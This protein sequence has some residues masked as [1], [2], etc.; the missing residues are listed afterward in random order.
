MVRRAPSKDAL[1]AEYG[2]ML[3]VSKMGIKSFNRTIMGTISAVACA[4]LLTA[5]CARDHNIPSTPGPD[6]PLDHMTEISLGENNDI[7]ASAIEDGYRVHAALTQLYGWFQHFDN[8]NVPIDHQ[9]ALLSENA[10]LTSDS[11]SVIGRTNYKRAAEQIPGDWQN[12]HFVRNVRVRHADKDAIRLEADIIYLNS[13]ALDERKPYGAVL[14]FQSTLSHEKSGL[15]EIER[16]VVLE[17]SSGISPTFRSAY[18]ENRLKSLFHH[19][20]YLIASPERSADQF[21][22]I[23]SEAFKINFP[24]SRITSN[25]GLADWLAGPAAAAEAMHYQVRDFDYEEL[26]INEYAMTVELD[27]YGLMENGDQLTGRVVQDFTVIDDP[28][29]AFAK[30]TAIRE[31]EVLPGSLRPDDGDTQASR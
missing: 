18:A 8:P 11:Q 4:S 30:I 19:W 12:A 31:E 1:R 17:T 26:G 20:I 7:T 16:L 6:A 15:P 22:D 27:W 2:A 23:L 24:K 28:S 3:G 14:D 10:E 9:L 29:A 21:D 13:G 5:G 25:E